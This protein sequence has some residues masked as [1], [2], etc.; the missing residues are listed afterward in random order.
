MELIL[1][2][3]LLVTLTKTLLHSLLFILLIKLIELLVNQ[4]AP[5]H[6]D[7]NPHCFLCSE[8]SR[9]HTSKMATT[10]SP[11]NDEG[12][13]SSDEANPF[14]RPDTSPHK[15][16][17][18]FLSKDWLDICRVHKEHQKAM[19]RPQLIVSAPEMEDVE[20][21]DA[22]PIQQDIEM[23]DAPPENSPQHLDPLW[24]SKKAAKHH[25][26]KPAYG[27]AFLHRH[28]AVKDKGF[29]HI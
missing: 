24:Q 15:P 1:N 28:Q 3:R 14:S 17:S 4:R 27:K 21:P 18:Y 22:D 16:G 10:K 20:M 11:L 12:Y 6:I 13:C 9:N 8:I 29:K 5:R 19:G 26:K 25:M 7:Q 23:V 2:W